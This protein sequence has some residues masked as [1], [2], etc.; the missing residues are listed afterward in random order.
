MSRFEE[1]EY[2][3]AMKIDRQD[4]P[5]STP[6]DVV[7]RLALSRYGESVSP[8]DVFT[9]NPGDKIFTWLSTM[10]EPGKYG[11]SNLPPDTTLV[12]ASR[13]RDPDKSE[14]IGA[15]ILVTDRFAQYPTHFAQGETT[16][17]LLVHDP[18]VVSTY[19]VWKHSTE[20]MTLDHVA[21]F[22][23]NDEMRFE[24]EPLSGMSL[25]ET[26]ADS[27]LY[28]DYTGSS[29]NKGVV[30]VSKEL[31]QHFLSS[32][33]PKF[34]VTNEPVEARS[35][36]YKRFSAWVAVALDGNTRPFQYVRVA[37]TET[38]FN[39]LMAP[40]LQQKAIAYWINEDN[41]TE[42]ELLE[43]GVPPEAVLLYLVNALVR[44]RVH[45]TIQRPLRLIK[46][47]A[48][49][50]MRSLSRDNVDL[51]RTI[52][53]EAK[54][55]IYVY[56]FDSWPRDISDANVD[57]SAARA[58]CRTNDPM[59][60]HTFFVNFFRE[61]GRTDV[62][63]L[64]REGV[65]ID[66]NLRALLRLEVMGY[67]ELIQFTESLIKLG[68]RIVLDEPDDT[69]LIPTYSAHCC[70]SEFPYYEPLD[71]LDERP[72][73]FADALKSRSPF[74]I[75][76]AHCILMAFPGEERRAL[77]GQ[78]AFSSSV[79]LALA[80]RHGAD[81]VAEELFKAGARA[82]DR[83]I[84]LLDANSEGAAL[85]SDMAE[86]MYTRAVANPRFSRVGLAETITVLR[87]L[88]SSALDKMTSPF[89]YVTR[90]SLEDFFGLAT[91]GRF[92]DETLLRMAPTLN[93]HVGPSGDTILTQLA[94]AK[95]EN[96]ERNIIFLL[97]RGANPWGMDNGG[98]SFADIALE[99]P[100]TFESAIECMRSLYVNA[101]VFNWK[102]NGAA[103]ERLLPH[104]KYDLWGHYSRPP[105]VFSAIRHANE[106]M[107]ED[108]LARG[109]GHVMWN[110]MTPLQYAKHIRSP[111]T[112]KVVY[113]PLADLDDEN[114]FTGRNYRD[115]LNSYW[116]GVFPDYD[117]LVARLPASDEYMIGLLSE[118]G[119]FR[120]SKRF[121][122]ISAAAEFTR[123][124]SLKLVQ[125]LVENGLDPFAFSV[126]PAASR[127]YNMHKDELVGYFQT[128]V[129]ERMKTIQPVPER[130]LEFVDI[131]EQMDG[132]VSIYHSF[133]RLS[134]QELNERLEYWHDTSPD[135]VVVVHD[136]IGTEI[137]ASRLNEKTRRHI[138]M[139]GGLVYYENTPPSSGW[140]V[141]ACRMILQSHFVSPVDVALYKLRFSLNEENLRRNIRR[142]E[143]VY[144]VP[145]PVLG[146][147]AAALHYNPSLAHIV[148]QFPQQLFFF[149]RN[150]AVT[151]RLTWNM[152][153]PDFARGVK[154]ANARGV[155]HPLLFSAMEEL[156]HPLFHVR[157][158]AYS[159]GWLRD[160][161][162]L[163]TDEQNI[164][165]GIQWSDPFF[166]STLASTAPPLWND[167]DVHEKLDAMKEVSKY[168]AD[169]SLLPPSHGRK[170]EAYD[171]FRG[172][173]RVSGGASRRQVL[174]M[175]A[176]GMVPRLDLDVALW[177]RTNFAA[178]DDFLS[179]E[180]VVA[181]H[182]FLLAQTTSLGCMAMCA[183]SDFIN[184]SIAI[185][186]SVINQFECTPNFRRVLLKYSASEARDARF[187]F[188]VPEDP[189]ES[190]HH[191]DV[192][193]LAD[194]DGLSRFFNGLRFLYNRPRA[195]LSIFAKEAIVE[196]QVDDLLVN[197]R[198]NPMLTGSWA[199][200][201]L[202]MYTRNEYGLGEHLMLSPGFLQDLTASV[203]FVRH[204]A[205]ARTAL[206]LRAITDPAIEYDSRASDG[207]SVYSAIFQES[208]RPDY[209]RMIRVDLLLTAAVLRGAS[210]L[211]PV[212]DGRPFAFLLAAPSHFHEL[213]TSNRDLEDIAAASLLRSVSRA[214]PAYIPAR[215]YVTHLAL[216]IAPSDR[217]REDVALPRQRIDADV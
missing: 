209:A 55:P 66:Q 197:P 148:G 95:P 23:P 30:P 58:A 124:P 32:R 50:S 77:F 122:R 144:P 212:Y 215:S 99:D 21:N 53:M 10:F 192:A 72:E 134:I 129:R 51:Y 68:V 147:I 183:V 4:M 86:R 106:R 31:I 201:F 46:S 126:R 187:T 107:L 164:L 29:A 114:I 159:Q 179:Q 67:T 160:A 40:D 39:P 94:H 128:V 118:L 113:A 137:P 37:L 138:D 120:F 49:L 33:N 89:Y 60:I 127:A 88:Q 216:D 36:L 22:D 174:A 81:D 61:G 28:I 198:G 6:H 2:F 177:W 13:D 211:D 176:A 65:P 210:L 182:N 199:I 152:T 100:E 162:F 79:A 90:V 166:D 132:E 142:W 42:D 115:I 207:L 165:F 92:I 167:F 153:L 101:Q 52:C 121:P 19:N 44:E 181:F 146:W 14:R 171:L 59:T 80:L 96:Y 145:Y 5:D 97:E 48:R 194:P 191:G 1:G 168:I 105:L 136:L 204:A 11:L 27:V 208:A 156:G 85:Y 157:T 178:D 25:A 112:S 12:V 161:Q 24:V 139:L 70:L 98:T 117:A 54:H 217:E 214:Y 158:H 184:L 109:G 180:H 206:A 71:L 131:A 76:E 75:E 69:D 172:L 62:E 91:D 3:S 18:S 104:L 78:H 45:T 108:V 35:S 83:L 213:D 17:L 151:V 9:V 195:G 150:P 84:S 175:I 143:Y 43:A 135:L 87:A 116:S 196:R 149:A 193:D 110:G 47:G 125:T 41:H 189:P 154:E 130:S 202:I 16:R 74:T 73:Y 173:S 155:R 57:F 170:K 119:Y 185:D 111:I 141:G 169:L 133:P 163:D 34:P 186:I 15:R 205:T 93:F 190:R 188:V 123:G 64:I 38:F 26:P 56:E 20:E 8:Q 103:G 140:D 102:E 203:L 200:R 63:Q 7:M 82:D